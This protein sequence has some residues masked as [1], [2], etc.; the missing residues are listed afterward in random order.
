M[1]VVFIGAGNVASALAIELYKY[2]FDI[3]QIYSRTT[4]SATTLAQLVNA[5]ATTDLSTIADNADLYIFSVKDSVLADIASQI[6]ANNGLW[7]HTAGS[8]PH[9]IFSPYTSRY[10]V[11]YPF[12]TFTKGREMVWKEIPVFVEASN[13]QTLAVLKEIANKISDKVAELSS[14][15]RKYIHLTGVFACNFVNHMYTLS[16]QILKEAGLPFDVALPLIDET[17]LKVHTLSP[18]DAQTGPAVRFDE[19]VMNK[20]LSLIED[21]KIREIYKLISENI[22]AISNKNNKI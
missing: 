6:P 16:E 4:Q 14:D 2:D 7:I 5:A 22:H 12:Q 10:G 8:I 1:K 13:S 18:I 11:L 3:V 21:E 9:E 17:S 20:H 19:N 15:K